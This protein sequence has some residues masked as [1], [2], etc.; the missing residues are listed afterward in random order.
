M[1]R[2]FE[3]II[4]SL[5]W[6]F[7]RLIWDKLNKNTNSIL[8]GDIDNFIIWIEYSRGLKIIIPLIFNNI[9]IKFGKC[10]NNN[11]NLT[12]CEI[13]IIFKGWSALLVINHT[14]FNKLYKS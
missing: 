2:T 3:I 11:E 7:W 12:G 1:W 14:N 13:N 4:W 6:K 8:F 10:L 5:I 9:D